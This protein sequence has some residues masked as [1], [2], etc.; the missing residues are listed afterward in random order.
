MVQMS[1]FQYNIA[2]KI[3]VRIDGI[4]LLRI[5]ENPSSADTLD[6]RRAQRVTRSLIILA[7][8]LLLEKSRLKLCSSR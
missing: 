3:H 2:P 6:T 7:V 5:D 8:P 4:L 1:G